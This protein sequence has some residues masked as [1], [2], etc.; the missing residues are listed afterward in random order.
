MSGKNES[1]KNN[2][3]KIPQKIINAISNLEPDYLIRSETYPFCSSDNNNIMEILEESNG[4]ENK[5]DEKEYKVGNYQIKRTLGK[6]TFGK[7]KLGIYIPTNEKVAIKILEKSKIVEKD[8]E[9]RVKREFEML[10]L[11]S[12]PNVILVAEIFESG[13][14]FYS[15][16]EYCEGGELFNYI[17]KNRRLSQDEAAFFYY[18]LINGLEYIHSLGIVHRDLKPENLL[19]TKDHILKII[20]FGLSNYF[21]KDQKDLLIT[22]C[23][24]P[25]YASPEM[26]A[27][28]KYNGFKIDIW[29]TGIILYAMLCGYLPFED[30]DNDAL[31]EKI[32]ECKLVFPKYI[33]KLGKNLIEKILVK[34]PNRRIT[35]KEIKEHPFYL[36]G[37]ELFEQEFSICQ[38]ENNMDEINTDDGINNIMDIHVLNYNNDSLNDDKKEIEGKNK[39]KNNEK[40][41]EKKMSKE[42]KKKIPKNRLLLN[43]L[44]AE[45]FILRIK[46]EGDE[47]KQS[48]TLRNE[49]LNNLD[50]DMDGLL[51]K[52]NNHSSKKVVQ[53][54]DKNKNKNKKINNEKYPFK[55]RDIIYT[56]NQNKN[57]KREQSKNIKKEPNKTYRKLNK[58]NKYSNIKNQFPNKHMIGKSV[59]VRKIN[60]KNKENNLIQQKN[61]FTNV[62]KSKFHSKEKIDKNNISKKENIYTNNI[63]NIT[64]ASNFNKKLKL[65][66]N[67]G[68]YNS[69][70]QSQKKNNSTAKK[71]LKLTTFQTI[72]TEK[73]NKNYLD[74]LFNIQSN[75]KKYKQQLKDIKFN[76]EQK[77][78]LR[79]TIDNASFE[80]RKGHFKIKSDILSGEINKKINKE[81][82]KLTKI[83]NNRIDNKKNLI[84]IIDN[85]GEDENR[86]QIKQINVTLNTDREQNI[87]KKIN[88]E[89]INNP[90]T[91][92]DMPI[93]KKLMNLKYYMNEI[94]QNQTFRN[95]RESLN[96]H[97]HGLKSDI[98]D[99]FEKRKISNFNLKK[100]LINDFN[101]K[102]KKDKKENILILENLTN[103]NINV[104]N[105]NTIDNIN[106]TE[107]NQI[108]HITKKI[109]KKELKDNNYKLSAERNHVKRRISSKISSN[110]YVHLNSNNL[111]KKQ[112]INFNENKIMSQINNE[113]NLNKTSNDFNYINYSIMNQ[114][115]SKYKNIFDMNLEQKSERK[116]KNIEKKFINI[117]RNKNN[118]KILTNNDKKPCVTIK[119]T[120]INLNIDTGIIINPFDK[121]EKIK[122]INSKKISNYSISYERPNKNNNNNYIKN[123]K[124]ISNISHHNT[125][126]KPFQTINEHNKLLTLNE[127]INSSN[128]KLGKNIRV[129]KERNQMKIDNSN[130]INSNRIPNKS[131]NSK[132]KKH[133]KYN[134]VKIDENMWNKLNNKDS[135]NLYLKTNENFFK[136]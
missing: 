115:N 35:I 48:L 58:T 80:N 51:A 88:N 104:N 23:G 9:I 84:N 25:C 120:V 96:K 105:L 98:I 21:K 3:N 54:N 16:M 74:N 68:L 75:I 117:E 85:T 42:K 20:D 111:I 52:T 15:V 10:T 127:E 133:M 113:K 135:K 24:S 100:M 132:F 53:N 14:N 40:I 97:K 122:S 30:K 47:E 126:E 90:K 55:K 67:V 13:G 79:N 4:K 7:V 31:F 43:G 63:N 18:Q 49:Y 66:F 41:N 39:N 124:T 91:N 65:K 46:T 110:K 121:N 107:P 134:S 95:K 26:V 106:R 60:Y 118:K 34:N 45:N 92:R 29:S 101:K 44:D 11:F 114:I 38:I 99:S 82:I 81:N 2:Q 77:L 61:N 27:G 50:K 64:N 93:K 123:E 5:E 12:H 28:K 78:K 86:N 72:E 128:R 37:K 70:E 108:I 109:I 8:D 56:K 125:N 57:I 103:D 89:Q 22:P 130:I 94:E 116:S 129:F 76:D 71:N 59:N 83:Y 73:N 32:L 69:T 136:H 87:I 1:E 6:G 36:K 33:P 62:I 19:L 119:N 17:V 102:A 112:K 131:M